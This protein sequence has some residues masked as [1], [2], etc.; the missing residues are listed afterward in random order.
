MAASPPVA[1]G[2]R[3]VRIDV[4]P[5]RT[6]PAFRRLFIGGLVTSLGSM[7]TYVAIPF[8]V[9]ELT[10]SF[11][12]VGL[13]GLAELVP[14]VVFGLYGGSLADRVD[15]RLLVVGGEIA[16]GLLVL[17]LM[18]NALLPSPQLWVIYVVAMLF[19]AV[20]GL[21]RPSLD[22]MLPRLV[23]QDQLAAASALNSLRMNSAALAGPALGGLMISI[24]GVGAAY[25][26]DALSF[27]IAITIFVRL[28]SVRATVTTTQS[29][30]RHVWSGVRY[31]W[32]RKDILG[33]YTIDFA[34][35]TFAFPFALFPFIAQEYDAAWALGLLYS[36]GFAGG[37]VFGLT[38]GWTT[39]IPHY[40]RAIAFAAAAWGAAVGLV[41]IAPGIW[42]A[43]AL[44]AVAGYFDMLSG[45]FRSLLWNQSIPDDV[46]GRMAGIEMLSYSVGPMLGQVRSTT[47]AQ[48][49][50][51]RTSLASGGI[52]CIAAVGVT[53]VTLP[54]LWIFDAR[55]DPHV[56]A[57]RHA[58]RNRTS[59]GD[60]S[61]SA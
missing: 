39:R 28:P 58:E 57:R 43:L 8:Q 41:S 37:L 34:A 60:D 22:A 50:G 53:C 11:I 54:A 10:D 51:L 49:F 18:V 56:A 33:S 16:A 32:S 7:V 45:H 31:A 29:S 9:A 19:A 24:W 52:L 5:L 35:M 4:T 12:A 40:G 61:A 36:A 17:A 26:F 1:G 6:L 48:A 46:R 20:D 23:P 47:A 15:R 55:T 59:S 13:I 30:V 3:G 25:A 42:W 38:S 14:L 44:L 27:V 2:L 21:Q